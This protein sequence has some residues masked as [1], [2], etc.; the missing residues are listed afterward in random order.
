[1]QSK[2][3]QKKALL[4]EI[5]AMVDEMLEWEEKNPAPTL[6]E[7]EE[8]VLKLRRQVAQRVAEFLLERQEGVQ[9]VPGPACPRCGQ[10]MRYKGRGKVTV[11]S[12]VGPLEIERG[13]YYCERCRSGFFPPGPTTPIEG[14]T[15]E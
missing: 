5:E 7:I 3:E 14:S 12:R 1:M 8:V 4:V 10:E 11:E 13:Y 6:T 2:Q 9:P 15:L